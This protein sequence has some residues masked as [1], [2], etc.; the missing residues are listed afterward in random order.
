M[1]NIKELAKQ[2]LM[3]GNLWSDTYFSLDEDDKNLYKSIVKKTESDDEFKAEKEDIHEKYTSN[4]YPRENIDLEVL[5]SITTGHELRFGLW[6]EDGVVFFKTGLIT[7]YVEAIHGG[8]ILKLLKDIEEYEIDKKRK[9]IPHFSRYLEADGAFDE[10]PENAKLI[11]RFEDGSSL[12]QSNGHY[13][14][15][16]VETYDCSSYVEKVIESKDEGFYCIN[17][18]IT[19]A[20]EDD[21]ELKIINSLKSEIKRLKMLSIDY[22]K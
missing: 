5:D 1:N 6:I 7:K 22:I 20:I 18:A 2:D 12:H 21:K 11:Y 19:A 14:I 10:I 17:A 4:A 13:F 9:F 16:Y 8:E 15:Q 3:M